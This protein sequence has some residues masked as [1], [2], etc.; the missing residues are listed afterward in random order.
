MPT[1]DHDVNQ[2]DSQAASIAPSLIKRFKT[3]EKLRAAFDKHRATTARL[4][5]KRKCHSSDLS[6]AISQ[7]YRIAIEQ[8]E[9]EIR[10]AMQESTTPYCGNTGGI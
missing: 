7:A 5:D 8:T 10:A 3:P 9:E 2:I 6:A 4:D 1:P